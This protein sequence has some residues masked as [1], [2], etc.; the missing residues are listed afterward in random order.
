MNPEELNPYLLRK[1][2]ESSG[3]YVRSFSNR[4]GN[5]KRTRDIEESVGRELKRLREC[6]RVFKILDIGCGDGWLIY[7][8]KAVFDKFFQLYFTGIDISGLDIDFANKRKEY[9]GHKDCDFQLMDVGNL[10]FGSEEFDIVISSE[11]VEHMEDPKRFFKS[12]FGILKKDGLVI[13]TTPNA[14]GSILAKAIRLVDRLSGGGIKKMRKDTE[15]CVVSET[16]R[17]LS[18]FS[19]SGGRTGAGLDHVSVFPLS[20]WKKLCK[21]GGLVLRSA[22][23]TSGF[24]YGDPFLDRHRLLFAFLVIADTL[25]E[26]VPGSYIWSE[27]LFFE[28]RKI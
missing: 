21:E 14:G 15:P 12:V 7:K 3:F 16:E 19:S 8:L 9:F 20:V 4:Y 18:R 6:R 27:T 2:E 1:L 25:L 17:G 5:W 24:L 23:G 22:K 10:L 28:L 13:L 26:R 11:V